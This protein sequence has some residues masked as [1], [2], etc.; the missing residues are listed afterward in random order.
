[1]TPGPG[2]NNGPSLEEGA[3]WRTH[4]WRQAREA[5]LPTL[6][7]AGGDDPSREDKS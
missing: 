4:C 7:S 1:V 6:P 3:A 5:L 2:H